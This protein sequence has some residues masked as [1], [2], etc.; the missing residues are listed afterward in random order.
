[1]VAAHREFE[2]A[3]AIGTCLYYNPPNPLSSVFWPRQGYRPL[4]TT[5]QTSPA[6]ALR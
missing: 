6:W 1:M 4:W 3:G 5:W 2:R